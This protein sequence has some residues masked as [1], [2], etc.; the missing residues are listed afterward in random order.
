MYTSKVQAIGN[1][2]PVFPIHLRR[3]CSQVGTTDTASRI[4]LFLLPPLPPCRCCTVTLEPKSSATSTPGCT[5]MRE[6]EPPAAIEQPHHEPYPA[7]IKQPGTGPCSP[8]AEQSLSD[9]IQPSADQS[10]GSASGQ[11]VVLVGEGRSPRN[12]HLL[13]AVVSAEA[14]MV[15]AGA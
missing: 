10:G 12:E 9:P 5:A 4:R 15:V 7:L 14:M 8:L 13:C 1:L 11:G 3:H 2:L 6:P